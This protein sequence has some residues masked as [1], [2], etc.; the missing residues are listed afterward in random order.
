MDAMPEA[1]NQWRGDRAPINHRDSTFVLM[2]ARW[3]MLSESSTASKKVSLLSHF[4]RKVR[5]LAAGLWLPVVWRSD[6]LA[7]CLVAFT[8]GLH[9]DDEK[10]IKATA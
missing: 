6:R 7:G 9:A 5:L 8:F 10:R 1:V 4:R 2:N 3:R